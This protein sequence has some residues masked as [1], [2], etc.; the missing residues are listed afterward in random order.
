ME[1]VDCLN[2]LNNPVN[3]NTSSNIC[4]VTDTII[5]KQNWSRKLN[6]ENHKIIINIRLQKLFLYF[7]SLFWRTLKSYQLKNII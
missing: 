2:Y 7:L 5:L 4:N 6:W 1:Q 3:W